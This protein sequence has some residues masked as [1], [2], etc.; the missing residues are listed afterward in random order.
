MG[1]NPATLPYLF[2]T[3]SNIFLDPGEKM[4]TRATQW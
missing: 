1:N 4:L 2:L 3:F